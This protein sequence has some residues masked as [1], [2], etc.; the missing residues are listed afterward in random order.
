MPPDSRPPTP[1]LDWPVER[2]CDLTVLV[3]V[4]GGA[5]SVALLHL[6]LNSQQLETARR[7]TAA[8]PPVTGRLIVAHF[9]HGLRG[10][11]SDADERFVG[12]LA[13]QLGLRCELG[14]GQVGER[15]ALDGDGLEAAARDERYTFLLQ[16]AERVGARYIATAHTADDQAETVLHHIVRGTG[17]A[18]LSGIAPVRVL[19]PAV[20]LRRP[21]LDVRRDELRAYLQA[22]GQH[23]NGPLWREDASN[24]ELRFTRSRLRHELLPHLMERYNG[25]IVEALVRLGSLAGEA[26]AVIDALVNDLT[27]RVV[28]FEYARESGQQLTIDLAKLTEQ[29][30]YLVREVLIAAWTA[31]GWPRQAMTFGHW[32]QLAAVRERQDFPGGVSAEFSDGILRL[33]RTV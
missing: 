1:K 26:Q 4:S 13:K 33:R 31:Q 29:P 16:T 23:V 28:R 11:E 18:G 17:L 3:A 27:A 32:D 12:D 10:A 25:Q 8:Q 22:L 24:Q 9:N 2:W 20:T 5:D 15:A 7:A 14:R 6:L 19:S 30:A 21:L